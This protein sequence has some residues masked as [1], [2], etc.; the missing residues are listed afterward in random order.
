VILLLILFRSQKSPPRVAAIVA[1]TLV[2]VLLHRYRVELPDGTAK[3][4]AFNWSY[5]IGTAM[6]FALGYCLG[7]PIRH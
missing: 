2:I 5:P 6:T 1:G 3:Y 7:K 4:L